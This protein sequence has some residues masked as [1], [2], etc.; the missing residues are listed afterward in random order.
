MR[1]TFFN[2]G[3]AL[4]IGVFFSLMVVGLANTLPDTLS[5]GLIAQGVP[6][7]VAD[8]LAG[9]PPVGI[10]FAAFLGINPI[11]ALLGP[12][13]VLS[14]LP[15][16]NVANLTGNDFFPALISDPFHAGLVLVFAISALMMVVAAIASWFAGKRPDDERSHPDAGER[17]GEEP[18]SYAAVEGE[19]ADDGVGPLAH[20]LGFPTAPEDAS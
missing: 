17:L 1:M 2:S 11:A 13:G 19:P 3:S 10:L 6:S 16:S 20:A 4:S 5:G 14:S 12:T 9:L 7:G 18:E 15:A 8:N